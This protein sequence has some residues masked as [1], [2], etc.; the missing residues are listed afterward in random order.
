MKL[1]ALSEWNKADFKKNGGSFVLRRSRCE[2]EVIPI[3]GGSWR[4][5]VRTPQGRFAGDAEHL[6]QACGAVR[7]YTFAWVHNETSRKGANDR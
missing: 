1:P 4:W 6:D 2:G 7:H 5:W 3:E